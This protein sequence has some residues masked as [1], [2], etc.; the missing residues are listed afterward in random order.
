MLRRKDLIFTDAN[1]NKNEAKFK[2]QGQS[3]ISQP[4]FDLEFDW[5]ELNFSTRDTNFFKKPFQSHENTQDTFK[6]FQVPIENSKYVE[7]FKFH[8]DAP[9]LKYCQKSLNSCFFSGSALQ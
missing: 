1:K 2:F 9:I 6:L 8:N 7:T 4:W 3:A 5:I